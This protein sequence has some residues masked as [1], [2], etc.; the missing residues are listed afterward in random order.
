MN[1]FTGE[2]AK[3]A[4]DS[5][6]PND[7]NPKDKIEENE[8]N[9]RKYEEVK[10]SLEKKT[11]YQPILVREHG[12]GYQ[13]IDGYHRW[14][15][16]KELGYDEIIVWNLGNISDEQAIGITV[17]DVYLKIPATDILI[18]QLVKRMEDAGQD[19]EQLPYDSEQIQHFRDLADFDWD[20]FNKDKEPDLS[21]LN[22]TTITVTTEQ[23]EII[24]QAV[25]KIRQD[26]NE[27]I[28]EG[29]ALEL[30]CAD[31]LAG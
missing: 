3:V 28:S 15:A 30:I 21:H 19:L 8:Y 29:R 9:R 25:A 6:V 23:K 2:S 5:V 4:I 11:Q 18:A 17:D 16:L 20:Q 27:E 7:W 10:K 13:I 14:R 22:F 1:K 12:K 31:Y 24:D 26:Q